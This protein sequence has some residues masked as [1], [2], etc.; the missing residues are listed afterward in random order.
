MFKLQA[1]NSCVRIIGEIQVLLHGPTG[2]PKKVS[3]EYYSYGFD[4]YMA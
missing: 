2:N 4:S 3:C 1:I